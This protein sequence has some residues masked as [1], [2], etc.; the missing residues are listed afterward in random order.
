[1][2]SE[3]KHP[4]NGFLTAFGMTKKSAR[5]DHTAVMLNEVKHLPIC[6]A[7][8][9]EASMQWIP[10]CVRNDKKERSE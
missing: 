1:M 8:R 6:H 2:L 9:S 7:E 3:A 10:H 5:N 4:C